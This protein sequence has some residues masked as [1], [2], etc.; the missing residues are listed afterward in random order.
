MMFVCTHYE[1][2][3]RK[4]SNIPLAVTFAKFMLGLLLL[5]FNYWPLTVAGILLML[6]SGKNLAVRAG[7]LMC[8]LRKQKLAR[9]RGETISS[10]C[11]T[12]E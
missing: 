9:E 6:W 5:G 10:S 4:V 12:Y 11:F 8:C 7:I 2:V 3:S 1:E